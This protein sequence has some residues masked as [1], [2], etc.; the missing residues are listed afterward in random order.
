VHA[1]DG[2]HGPPYENLPGPTLRGHEFPRLVPKLCLGTL[3]NVSKLSLDSKFRSQVQ[4]GNENKIFAKEKK[5]EAMGWNRSLYTLS[6]LLLLAW[7][8]GWSAG[9]G[10]A[11]GHQGEA[12]P[13]P[14]K[15][16]IVLIADGCGAEH[17]TLARWFK[18]EPLA[19]DQICVGAVK[20]YI[21]DSVVADSAPASTAFATGVRTNDKLIGMGPR[22]P[23]LPVVPA[24]APEL[25]YKP[26]ATVLEGAKLLGKATGLAVTS[27]VTHATPAAYYAHVPSRTQDNDIMEQG[28]YQNLDVVLGGGRRHLLPQDQGG[29]RT[30][31]ENLLEILKKRGY[32][33]TAD[34][35]ELSRVKSGKVYGLFADNH[36]E[37]EI[38][39]QATAPG[40]PTLEDM[41]TKAIELLSQDPDGFFLL[42]EGSQVDWASH[43]NDPAHLLSDLLMFDRAVQAALDFARKDGNTLVLAF[44]DHNCG[45]LSIGNYGTSVTYTRMKLEDLVGP[46]KKMKL[47]AQAVWR[48]MGPEVT[49][50]NLQRVVK[51]Y[52]GLKPTDA[53]AAQIITLAR[54][55]GNNPHNALGE[56]LCR[57]HTCLGWTTHG[58]TGGDV[59]LFAFG[60]HRP[61]GLVDGP[62]IGHLC[63]RALGLDLD[64]LNARLFV[65]AAGALGGGE[66]AMDRSDPQ[67]PVVK[68][69]Y[70]GKKAELP[71]NTNLLR[72]D[73]RTLPLEGLVVHAS[74]TGKVYLPL[75]AVNLIKG[76]PEALPSIAPE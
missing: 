34:A 70:Q 42:V 33:V 2:G 55:Y 13:P 76:S 71:V 3:N 56:I 7:L 35:S 48:R 21:A 9:C 47:S 50:E 36:L 29:K 52:W 46:L 27:R 45:G 58:H 8:A 41:V 49:P 67:N 65:N 59:P 23:T 4:L 57:H 54:T 37:A 20:T 66:V 22:P 19:L 68:I 38:D 31:G 40:Q 14:V 60:P 25:A 18:G 74:P 51:E 10:A 63:A 1:D 16:L 44:S 17:Y 39:R 30:D 73:G 62:D 43:A 28:V 72:L 5:G 32:A 64:R 15:N 12:A 6:I 11:Q 61:V 69:S 24:P 53:E 26:L 75:Q